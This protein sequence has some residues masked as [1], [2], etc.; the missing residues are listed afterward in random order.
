MAVLSYFGIGS[1]H[2]TNEGGGSGAEAGEGEEAVAHLLHAD[3]DVALGVQEGR[4][5]AQ[6]GALQHLHVDGHALRVALHG[7]HLRA[8]RR[9]AH[10]AEQC[11]SALLISG[12]SVPRHNVSRQVLTG[13]LQ[14]LFNS[15]RPILPGTA[16]R[17][18]PGGT[19]ARSGPPAGEWR[20]LRAR[21]CAPDPSRSGRSPPPVSAA[22]HL[23]PASQTLMLC[24]RTAINAQMVAMRM[25]HADAAA[26]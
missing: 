5:H 18:P 7:P 19:R 1:R 24:I 13:S 16:V 17:G 22:C 10:K 9:A 25:R 21:L 23:A 15:L 3:Q 11:Q 12:T 6:A 26:E 14:Q 8:A 2:G 20:S 4:D